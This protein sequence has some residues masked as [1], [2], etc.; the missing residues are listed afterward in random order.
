[1][2]AAG[3]DEIAVL[4][5]RVSIRTVLPLQ[6]HRRHRHLRIA[7]NLAKHNFHCY[8]DYQLLLLPT[9]RR[10]LRYHPDGVLRHTRIGSHQPAARHHL[11]TTGRLPL[12]TEQR[13]RYVQYHFAVH[14]LLPN[15]SEILHHVE[16][17]AAESFNSPY[18][19][20]RRNGEYEFLHSWA[21]VVGIPVHH[22]VFQRGSAR[23]YPDCYWGS[24][25]VEE[26]PYQKGDK[27]HQ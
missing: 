6:L 24:A 27:P 26:V 9:Q 10:K 5:G 3:I 25:A 15:F 23:A 12:C 4:F 13:Q 16:W 19:K 2:L 7:A 1:M 21:E 22:P 14:G 8:A 18:L 11:V 20:H 17:P